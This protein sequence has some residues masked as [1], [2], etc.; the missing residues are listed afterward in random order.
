MFLSRSPSLKKEI[1]ILV[2]KYEIVWLKLKAQDMEEQFK[3]FPATL[4]QSVS[5]PSHSNLVSS[6]S[7]CWQPSDS[8]GLYQDIPDSQFGFL[9]F[10]PLKSFQHDWLIIKMLAT[11]GVGA[12]LR[13]S[14]GSPHQMRRMMGK[15]H[16]RPISLHLYRLRS[17]L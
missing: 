11:K 10:N 7:K 1:F 13:Y 12:F 15:T 14:E 3:S 16:K 6:Q 9:I 5:P 4:W 17:S 8:S 2:S